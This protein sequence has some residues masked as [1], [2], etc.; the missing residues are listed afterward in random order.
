MER[1]VELAQGVLVT[2]AQGQHPRE[3]VIARGVHRV[4]LQCSLRCGDRRGMVAACRVEPRHRLMRG[5]VVWIERHRLRQTALGRGEIPIEQKLSPAQR[6][7][8]FG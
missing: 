6:R 8:P 1:A 7:L 5:H 2:A 4:Q 3:F